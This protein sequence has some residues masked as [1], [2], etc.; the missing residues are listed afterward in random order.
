MTAARR[1]VAS[2]AMSVVPDPAKGSSTVSRLLD[3]LRIARSTSATGFMVGCR[4]LDLG[5]P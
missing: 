5:F 2:A 4:S 3:E 1:P